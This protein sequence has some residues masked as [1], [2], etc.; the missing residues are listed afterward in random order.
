MKLRNCAFF[1]AFILLVFTCNSVVY[2]QNDIKKELKDFDFVVYETEN[3]YSGFDFKVNKDNIK[4]YKSLKRKLRNQIKNGERS[5][6]DAAAELVGWFNDFHFSLGGNNIHSSKYMTKRHIDY[7]LKIKNYNPQF[8]SA[9]VTDKTFLIRI[10]NYNHH[11]SVKNFV[12]QAVEQFKES[13]CENLIIDERKNPGGSSD[14]FMPLVYLLSQYKGSFYSYKWLNTRDNRNFIDTSWREDYPEL[15]ER[16]VNQMSSSR[17]KYIVLDNDSLY[18]IDSVNIN[19]LPI[20]TAVLIDNCTAS[21]GE[22]LIIFLRACSQ[23]FKVY[24]RDNTAGCL[25]F[26]NA[27]QML[28]PSKCGG[29]NVPVSCPIFDNFIDSKGIAPD[30]IIP[31]DYPEN[32]IDN[33]D[34]WVIWTAQDLEK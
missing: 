13:G 5:G 24:G 4:I 28:L 2:G 27:K 33:I 20:K 6:V 30:V 31:L 14:M 9:K 15:T 29:I 25:D 19:P 23:R 3:N 17:D 22:F 8:V 16:L 32:L 11:D 21:S 12:I 34:S 1:I 7:S 18:T 10:P 26:A